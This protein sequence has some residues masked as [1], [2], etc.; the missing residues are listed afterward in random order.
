MILKIW[1]GHS[2]LLFKCQNLFFPFVQHSNLSKYDLLKNRRGITLY[3][4]V[5][6]FLPLRGNWLPLPPFP[7]ASVSPPP[8]WNQGD[9]NT[10]LQVRVRGGP[11]R[12]AGEKAWY[13]VHSQLK[14]KM[15]AYQNSNVLVLTMEWVER[16]KV[17][18]PRSSI[19]KQRRH[20]FRV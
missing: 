7:S 16:R 11:I 18:R 5:P 6:E 10:R 17:C 15:V 20:V 8:P 9:G 19:A 14:T 2:A 12:T 13:S 1:S 3:L 4:E